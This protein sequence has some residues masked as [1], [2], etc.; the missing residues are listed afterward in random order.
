MKGTSG[1][2]FP[3]FFLYNRCSTLL[4]PRRQGLATARG[5]ESRTPILGALNDKDNGCHSFS[6]VKAS[7]DSV[8]QVRHIALNDNRITALLYYLPRGRIRITG[9]FKSGGDGGGFGEAAKSRAGLIADAGPPGGDATD[10][11]NFV[12]TIAR[13]HRTGSVRPLLP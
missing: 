9:D 7:T 3:T 11:K 4:K 2:K 13:Q 6:T 5:W 8:N 10:Q 12:V 1:I